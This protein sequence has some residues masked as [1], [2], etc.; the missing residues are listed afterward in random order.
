MIDEYLNRFDEIL[1][2]MADKMF[3]QKIENNIMNNYIYCITKHIEA[4]VALLENI[5]KYTNNK[6]IIELSKNVIE[7]KKKETH[8]FILEE[9]VDLNDTI[10]EYMIEYRKIIT[11]MIFKMYHSSKSENIDVNFIDEIIPHFE[12]YILI[13]KNLLKYKKNN[14]IEENLKNNTHILEKL[15]KIKREIET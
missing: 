6:N 14:L 10:N 3:L 12:G 15:L 5:L 13:S 4:S 7:I 8:G 9:I 2:A 1:C 11:E